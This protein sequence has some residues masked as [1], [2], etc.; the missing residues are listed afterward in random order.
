MS[1]Q[2]LVRFRG[3]L[4]P[5]HQLTVSCCLVEFMY[6]FREGTS[7]ARSAQLCW[8]QYQGWGAAQGPLELA[9]VSFWSLETPERLVPRGA[10]VQLEISQ[11]FPRCWGVSGLLSCA[12]PL[13]RH[14]RLLPEPGSP[15]SNTAGLTMLA[16][17]PQRAQS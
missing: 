11:A 3:A 4:C 2:S 6:P 16:V 15:G 1:F 14:H 13:P 9:T 5:H 17:G 7:S 12:G 8:R 10:F